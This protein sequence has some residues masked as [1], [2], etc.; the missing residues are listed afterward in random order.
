M[1][2][3]LALSSWDS[4]EARRAFLALCFSLIFLRHSSLCASVSDACLA[5]SRAFLFCRLSAVVVFLLFILYR[6]N[7]LSDCSNF[8]C[9]CVT[10]VTYGDIISNEVHYRLVIELASLTQHMNFLTTI[11]KIPVIL[12]RNDSI[13]SR[14]KGKDHNC[15]TATYKQHVY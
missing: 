13:S 7:L 11:L 3:R 5:L 2:H 9:A 1:L 4:D 10:Y 6:N 14:I 15:R 12:V 8:K